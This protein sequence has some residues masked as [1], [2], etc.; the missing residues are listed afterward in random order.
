MTPPLKLH[1][2][3]SGRELTIATSHHAI[4]PGWFSRPDRQVQPSLLVRLHASRARRDWDV[5]PHPIC[6]RT[7]EPATGPA[8]VVQLPEQGKVRRTAK[9]IGADRVLPATAA[10]R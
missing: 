1:G 2:D 4:P 5:L 7:V 10:P 6:T 3:G 9:V 8:P